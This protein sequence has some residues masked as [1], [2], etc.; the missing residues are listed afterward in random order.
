MNEPEFF[1]QNTMKGRID[2][3][4]QYL[5]SLEE[6]IDSVKDE[7]KKSRSITTKKIFLWLKDLYELQNTTISS[8]TSLKEWVAALHR[9]IGKQRDKV[10]TK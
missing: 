1:L 5:K 7:E 2:I 4:E 3:I 9:D 8:I 10:R 6:Y